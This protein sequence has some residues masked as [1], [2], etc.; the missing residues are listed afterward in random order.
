MTPGASLGAWEVVPPPIGL[1]NAG[2]K[3]SRYTKP[4]SVSYATYFALSIVT[5][6]A[7]PLVFTAASAAASVSNAPSVRAALMSW[8]CV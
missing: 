2:L 6:P 1:P 4:M 8:S 5:A 3:S 7:F